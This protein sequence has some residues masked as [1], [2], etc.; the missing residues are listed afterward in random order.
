MAGS[1]L[2]LYFLCHEAVASISG[3]SPF[4][5]AGGKNKATPTKQDRSGGRSSHAS[6]APLSPPD[7]PCP[8]IL[9]FPN[10]VHRPEKASKASRPAVDR[11]LYRGLWSR[12][13]ITGCQGR[14]RPRGDCPCCLNLTNWW[15]NPGRR[16]QA[17]QGQW[18]S[19]T[20]QGQVRGASGEEGHR[21]QL[22][23][24]P[25]SGP[26]SS[27]H[28]SNIPVIASSVSFPPLL[29][30]PYPFLLQDPVVSLNAGTLLTRPHPQLES[31]GTGSSAGRTHSD[32]PVARPS[33]HHLH[34]AQV[35][36]TC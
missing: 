24:L 29:H 34:R 32:L 18:G 12:I 8:G 11:P 30:T 22:R 17:P 10:W 3:P 1:A 19:Q 25:L 20:G 15:E 21:P 33:G 4:Y 27:P 26:L 28:F 9:L 13:R 2:Y 23:P 35:S 5:L 16:A 36:N 6:L 14:G 7:L 31:V